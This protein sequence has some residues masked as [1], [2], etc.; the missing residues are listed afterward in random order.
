MA[1]KGTGSEWL[2]S[3][4]YWMGAGVAFAITA[5]CSYAYGVSQGSEMIVLG[6]VSKKT[7]TGLWYATIDFALAWSALGLYRFVRKKRYGAAFGALVSCAV[8][9]PFAC[10]N[11]VG[12]LGGEMANASVHRNHDADNYAALEADV[13]RIRQE[14]GW[15]PEARPPAVVAADIAEKEASDAFGPTRTKGC[16]DITRDD[17]RKFCDDYRRLQTELARAGERV[18]ASEKLRTA[19]SRLA[20][21]RPVVAG[22]PL[23]GR[24]TGTIGSTEADTSFY[25]SAFLALAGLFVAT[26]FPVLAE[27]S[28]PVQDA[29]RKPVAAEEPR[30]AIVLPPIPSP[31]LTEALEAEERLQIT[32]QPETPKAIPEAPKTPSE[33][34]QTATGQGSD[35]LDPFE[36]AVAHWAWTLPVGDYEVADLKARFKPVAADKGLPTARMNQIGT[37]LEGMGYQKARVTT[38]GK[39]VTVIRV[40]KRLAAR[41]G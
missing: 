10:M 35:T 30:P 18:R 12:F 13:A 26:V 6:L 8:C 16:T 29:P 14:M 27:A 20:E 33:P 19:E 24:L 1:D 4:G 36:K 28:S 9:L 41:A 11:A 5:T 38:K 39:K 32:A 31:A 3:T 7:L 2:M 23:Y 17:S 25:I 37:I 40:Q 21:A 34:K 22:N 15:I